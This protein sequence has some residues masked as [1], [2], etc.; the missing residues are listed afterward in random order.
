MKLGPCPATLPCRATPQG[1]CFGQ[2][3]LQ[4]LGWPCK[5]VRSWHQQQRDT[6]FLQWT[7]PT[8]FW[9]LG[10]GDMGVLEGGGHCQ[11]WSLEWS[12]CF[13]FFFF[14]NN[15]ILAKSA[16]GVLA[17]RPKAGSSA[18]GGPQ[19]SGHLRL[20]EEFFLGSWAGGCCPSCECSHGGDPAPEL[21]LTE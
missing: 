8:V 1:P 21:S 13:V 2:Q 9:C 16:S 14:S 15:L 11:L 5:P 12:R 10:C 7:F 4:V 6:L 3:S 17:D 18:G 19:G 20:P